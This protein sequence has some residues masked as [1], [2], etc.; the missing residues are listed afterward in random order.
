MKRRSIGP[1][2]GERL[3]EI[4]LFEGVSLG[5]RRALG[6]LV[7]AVEVEAGEAIMVEG[8]RGYEFM[9]IEEGEA[10]V[11]QNGE[12]IRLLGPGEFF[13][14]LAILD[15]GTPRTAT[16]IARTPLRGLAFTAHFLRELHD[17]VP[18]VGERLDRE[19]RERLAR[20]SRAAGA[21]EP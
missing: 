1:D 21:R 4:P 15:D 19:A 7:D 10:E 17:R 13:G 20:D 12:R 9:M 8:S 16:V 6:R 3:G 14:E 5:Q 11:L 18:L 2:G